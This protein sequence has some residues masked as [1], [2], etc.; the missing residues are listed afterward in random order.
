MAF[1]WNVFLDLAATIAE[2]SILDKGM[3][4]PGEAINVIRLISVGFGS[5]LSKKKERKGGGGNGG[6]GVIALG[7]R[8]VRDMQIQR[9]CIRKWGGMQCVLHTL[10]A[11]GGL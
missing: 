10:S 8:R 3:E 11:A 2:G 1:S 6:G 4:T 9:Y 7:S 5:R